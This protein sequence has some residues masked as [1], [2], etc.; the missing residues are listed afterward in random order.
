MTY[1]SEK[2]V[3]LIEN[4]AVA[5]TNNWIKDI[6]KSD[7]TST[8][9]NYPEEELYKRGYNVISSL[10][11]W[12]SHQTTKDKIGV[13]YK[14]LGEKRRSEGFSLSEVISALAMLRRQI[15]LKVLSDGVLDTALDLHQALELNNRVVL[16]FDRAAYFIA[17]GYETADWPD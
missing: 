10:G 7:T 6:N 17:V 4:S 14:K 9:H 8:Y 2:L 13:H 5:L 16:Y 12:I 15:W 3:N 1:I 11:K